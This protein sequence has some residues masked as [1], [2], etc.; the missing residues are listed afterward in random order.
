MV[1]RVMEAISSKLDSSFSES[2]QACQGE[3]GT[4]YTRTNVLSFGI[5]IQNRA[6][7]RRKRQSPTKALQDM[8]KTLR[9]WANPSSWSYYIV[10]YLPPGDRRCS[11]NVCYM[12][13]YINLKFNIQFMTTVLYIWCE[14]KIKL[15]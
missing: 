8:S 5:I 14:E 11:I 12:H 3:M 6:R 15:Y 2:G 9:M 13:N 7:R 10:P 4:L 1:E